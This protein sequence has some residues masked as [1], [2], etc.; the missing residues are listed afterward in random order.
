MA[1]VEV[2]LKQLAF[3]FQSFRENRL[4]PLARFPSDLWDR[5]LDLADRISV[6]AVAK[7]C[8]LSDAQLRMRVKT[9]RQGGSHLVGP[10]R[11]APVTFDLSNVTHTS[12]TSRVTIR[13]KVG[14]MV[15]E[16]HS[17]ASLPQIVRAFVEGSR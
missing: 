16:P 8:C 3:D 7:A 17:D 5:A 4:T 11:V 13:S 6:R 1:S 14:E 15:I 12:A 2:E 10:V 9:S